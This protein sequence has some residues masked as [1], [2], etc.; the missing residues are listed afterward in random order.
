MDI[1]PPLISPPRNLVEIDAA[2]FADAFAR[3]SIAVRHGLADHP[4]FTIDAI[5]ELAD[6][7]PPESVRRERGDLPLANSG[8]G[9]VD[10]GTGAP[11]ETVRMSSAAE[12]GCLFEMFNKLRNMQS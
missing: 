2:A 5:A 12:S 3:R 7:L 4:L 10:V 11:S 6:R 8:F 9:Y 1:S